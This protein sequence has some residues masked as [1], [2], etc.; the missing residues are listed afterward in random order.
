MTTKQISVRVDQELLSGLLTAGFTPS[1]AVNRGLELLWQQAIAQAYD[2]LYAAPSPDELQAI[3][4]VSAMAAVTL[5]AP[6]KATGLGSGADA[7]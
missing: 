1:E 6:G 3:E 2:E 7:G 5:A 4:D